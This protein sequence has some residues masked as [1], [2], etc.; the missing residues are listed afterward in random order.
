MRSLMICTAQLNIIRVIKSRRM[1]WAGHIARVEER[2]GGYR[3][4]VKKSE[5]KRPRGRPRRRWENNIEK[6]PGSGVWVWTGL[7]W[8]MTRTDSGLL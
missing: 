8:L 4:L 5:E 6:D 7:I 2:R 3:V 1:S